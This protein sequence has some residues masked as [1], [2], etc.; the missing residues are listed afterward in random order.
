MCL[1]M[2]IFVAIIFQLLAP[3]YCTLDAYTFVSAGNDIFL[4]SPKIVDFGHFRNMSFGDIFGNVQ[5]R[6][7]GVVIGVVIGAK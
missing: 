2:T 5:I 4:G 1:E 6:H 3:I 7:T